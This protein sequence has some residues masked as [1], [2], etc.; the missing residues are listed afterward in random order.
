MEVGPRLGIIYACLQRWRRG[1]RRHSVL[2]VSNRCGMGSGCGCRGCG[3]RGLE[4]RH[5]DGVYMEAAQIVWLL[6]RCPDLLLLW[7]M[8][9]RA[10]WFAWRLGATHAM[11]MKPRYYTRHPVGVTVLLIVIATAGA[12]WYKRHAVLISMAQILVVEDPLVP[13]DL[14]IVSNASAKAAALEAVYL[15][16]EHLSPQIVLTTW[17]A[18]PIDDEVRRLGI[19]C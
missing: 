15:Y 11:V 1:K 7:T 8:G 19:L 9:R 3:G 6:C 10:G 12:G 16:R 14:V 13:V 4:L 5:D 17:V 2:L 18:N